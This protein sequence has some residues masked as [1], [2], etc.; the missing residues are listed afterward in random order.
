MRLPTFRFL[1]AAAGAISLSLAATGAFAAATVTTGAGY[2]PVVKKLVEVCQKDTGA[3]VSGSY[4]GNIGQMLAQIASGS[5]VNVVISDTNTLKRIKTDVKFSRTE[6]LGTTPM[7][8]VWRKGVMIKSTDDLATKA[9]S[10]IA[11]PDARAAIY[12]RTALEW[13]ANRGKSE[14]DAI[15]PKLLQVSGVPQVVSYVLRS[16]VDAGF[17]NYQAAMSNKDKLGGVMPVTDGYAPIEMAAFVVQGAE[18]DADVAA[19]LK[20]LKSE[21]ARK[22]LGK[23]GIK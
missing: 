19:F 15:K 6:M 22:V 16:E 3:A 21:S 5:G 17:V 4:G 1:S 20:C 8:L 14:Q 11:H 23:A 9:V 13:V 7:M 18:K 2:V 10:R 12:G